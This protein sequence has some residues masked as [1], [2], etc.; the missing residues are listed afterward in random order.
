MGTKVSNDFH[1]FTDEVLGPIFDDIAD[2]YAKNGCSVL[3]YIN[4][5]DPA[6]RAKLIRGMNH[7]LAG[8]EIKMI[9]NSF[10]KIGE[11]EYD[12]TTCI[13]DDSRPRCIIAPH[14]TLKPYAGSVN[15]ECLKILRQYTSAFVVGLNNEELGLHVDAMV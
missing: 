7:V 3:D 9:F 1:Q 14:Y 15:R 12:I 5:Q 6:K 13:N 11:I 2:R 4:S 8:R 10:T